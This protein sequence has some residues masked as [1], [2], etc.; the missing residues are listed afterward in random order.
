ML[1]GRHIR[2]EEHKPG[3]FISSGMGGGEIVDD[4]WIHP[5]LV[6]FGL[7]ERIR[8]ILSGK[9]SR[10]GLNPQEVSELRARWRNPEENSKYKG[11]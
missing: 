11:F 2:Y 1:E 6:D 7:L 9:S 3:D 10:L 4:V 5:Q 8:E